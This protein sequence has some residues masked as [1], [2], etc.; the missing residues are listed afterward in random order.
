MAINN[1]IAVRQMH[2]MLAQHKIYDVP[3]ETFQSL[4]DSFF[5][6]IMSGKIVVDMGDIIEFIKF[7]PTKVKSDF[8]RTAISSHWE[9]AGLIG[10]GN[11]FE[12]GNSGKLRPQHKVIFAA[13]YVV[14]LRAH[15]FL[16]EIMEIVP[17]FD[18]GPESD[19][20]TQLLGELNQGVSELI[21][22]LNE[23]PSRHSIIASICDV[24]VSVLFPSET[25]RKALAMV[26]LFSD[27]KLETQLNTIVDFKP[28]EYILYPQR[29]QRTIRELL[30]IR[31]HN[32][33]CL[34]TVPME[35]MFT[36][37]EEIIN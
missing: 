24:D 26:A 30:L 6:Y 22:L 35:M 2:M 23:H 32:E 36:L 14:S 19:T 11:C 27:T 1:N 3:L 10:N 4:N 18:D 34:N 31:N 15:I 17:I 25:S 5:E 29:I 33:N 21:K 16:A 8:L 12:I 7:H 20:P 37:F 13:L 28:Y 9:M